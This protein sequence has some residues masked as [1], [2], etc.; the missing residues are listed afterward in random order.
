MITMTIVIEEA[1]LPG[2]KAGCGLKVDTKGQDVASCT[3]TE[4]WVWEGICEAINSH[5]KS[6]GAHNF[7]CLKMKAEQPDTSPVLNADLPDIH[8]VKW[9]DSQGS[10]LTQEL[11]SFPTA[12]DVPTG[13]VHMEVALSIVGRKTVFEAGIAKASGAGMH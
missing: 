11:T 8:I 12:S 5:M 7:D 9:T 3:E 4:A 10:S 2:G 6:R 13:A 1:W